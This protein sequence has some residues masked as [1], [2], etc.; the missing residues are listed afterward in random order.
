[1]QVESVYLCTYSQGNE[2]V[3]GRVRAWDGRDAAQLFAAELEAEGS[4]R[5]VAPEEVRAVKTQ[6]LDRPRPSRV[7]AS[8]GPRR[9]A[10]GKSPR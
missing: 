10:S 4:G 5:R 9:R 1:M 6:P 8:R 2:R 3:T 7:S